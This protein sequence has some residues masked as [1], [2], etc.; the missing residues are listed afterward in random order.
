MESRIS[1]VLT[2]PRLRRE[3][4]EAE[5]APSISARAGARAFIGEDLH[6]LSPG[7]EAVVLL[8]GRPSLLVRR[9]R[10]EL[11][12][13]GS[14]ADILSARR[15]IIE[16]RL[17]SI[18][19]IEVDDGAGYRHCGTGWVIAERVIATNR[20]VAE[21]FAR[22]DGAGG[23]FLKSFLG[24]DMAAR[25]D[26][27]EEYQGGDAFEVDV[28]EIIFLEDVDRALPD[29]AFLKLAAHGNLP[30]PIPVLSTPLQPGASLAVVGYPA[31]DPRYGLDATEAAKAI[32]GTIYDVK[33]LSPGCVMSVSSRTWAFAHDATTLGGNSG[34]PVL[35]VDTGYVVGMHFL[36]DFR[37]ANYAVNASTLLDRALAHSVFAVSREPLPPAV[38]KPEV[39]A[40]EAGEEAPADNLANRTGYDTKFLG[41]RLTVPLPKVTGERA[42]QVLKFRDPATGKLTGTAKYTHFSVVMN[43]DR[44]LCFYSAVNIDG[45]SLVKVGGKRPGWRLDP[46]LPEEVQI[47]NECY[48]KETEGRFSRG[49]MTRREDPNWGSVELAKQANKDTFY[50]S[51]ATPQFQ[52]FNGGIWL[53][54]EEYALENADQDDM[55]ISVFTGPVFSDEDP[56]YFGVLVPVRFWKVIAFRHDETRKLCAT[57]YIMS[58]RDMLPGAE[59]VFGR[60]QLYQAPIAEIESLTGLS[61]G[62]LKN[63]DPL[64]VVEEAPPVPLQS[65]D[66]IRFV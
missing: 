32:F 60:F 43:N 26:F 20:H 2:D 16:A 31:F 12:R 65:P 10:F 18:G 13:S 44:R 22:K 9:N 45:K 1:S 52:P 6:G 33:R 24:S 5:V 4:A 30:P 58:Q 48:G 11:P 25:I 7:E 17:P 41:S 3:I 21:A 59:F 66:Q 55:R 54:L 36:G 23:R 50:V 56:V 62:K 63:A 46:R 15:D 61:F 39:E 57:G 38:P 53:R 37:R 19:R 35:D 51:N 64:R 42:G 40:P 28:Q 27:R 29:I 34:S 8:T 49:H 14:W 47:L